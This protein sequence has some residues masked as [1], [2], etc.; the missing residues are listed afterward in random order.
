MSEENA[1]LEQE[2]QYLNEV[3]S[4]LEEEIESSGELVAKQKRD[5]V[6]LRKEMFADGQGEG[7]KDALKQGTH[8]KKVHQLAEQGKACHLQ[9]IIPAIAGVDAAL[10]DHIGIDGEG[11]TTHD[12]QPKDT[13]EQLHAYVVDGHGEHGQQLQLVGGQFS[14]H[15]S[16]LRWR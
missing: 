1:I 4:F 9:Q 11:Q 10:G 14:F 12:A 2:K 8:G 3:I 6:A 7:H 13:G 5:L 15:G 16:L